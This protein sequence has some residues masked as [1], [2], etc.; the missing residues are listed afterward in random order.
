MRFVLADRPSVDS[1]TS[2]CTK[3]ELVGHRP[4][5]LLGLGGTGT[6]WDIISGTSFFTQCKMPKIDKECI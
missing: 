2:V 5:F 4:H 1:H 6:G 3:P